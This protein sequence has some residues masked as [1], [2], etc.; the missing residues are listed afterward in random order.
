MTIEE[1]AK[2][3]D[4]ALELAKKLYKAAPDISL[5]LEKLFP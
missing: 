3:Y 1:K 5:E 2:A 4:E